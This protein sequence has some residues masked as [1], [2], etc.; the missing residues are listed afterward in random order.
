MIPPRSESKVVFLCDAGPSVGG[1]H[2][3]RCLTLAQAVGPG[4]AFV[5][6]PEVAA[7]LDAFAPD[8]PRVAAP[9]RAGVLVLDHYRWTDEASLRRKVGRLVVL[10]DLARAHDCE[11]VVDPSFGRRAEEYAVP[12]L[13]GPDYALVR[14]QFREARRERSGPVK[15]ALVS[16]GLT[17][18]GGIT[19]RVAKALPPGVVLDVTRG[20]TS[21]D[22]MAAMMAAA[23]V[24]VGAGGSSV[25][26]RACAGLPSITLI[27]ADNQR[28]MAMKLDEAGAT[29]A[30]DARWPGLEGR[31]A[32]LWARLVGDEGLRASLAATSLALCDG[33]GAERVA[34]A[35]ETL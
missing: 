23:D 20:R 2:V 13:V 27:V 1:G 7:V 25:W 4:C 35:L 16:L 33:R 24:A 26:E 18:V 6:T 12:A 29:L 22:E 5:D 28:D 32:A 19:D 9:D 3:M 17:D 21:P 15:R 30:L 31:L 14:P 34:A 10:D 8:M 11:L